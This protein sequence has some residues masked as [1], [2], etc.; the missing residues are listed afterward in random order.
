MPTKEA[1]NGPDGRF[2]RALPV[3]LPKTIRFSFSDMPTDSEMSQLSLE[4]PLT[5]SATFC[6]LF[7]QV[8]ARL[9]KS[10]RVISKNLGN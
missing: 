9:W 10:I 1:G 8:T 2:Q 7:C 6:L 3:E 5:R 4:T